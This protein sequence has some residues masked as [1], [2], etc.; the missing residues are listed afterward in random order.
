MSPKLLLSLYTPDNRFLEKEPV[1]EVL[2]PSIKGELGL[3]PGHTDLISLLGSGILKYRSK[4]Q[5]NK[6]AVSWGYLEISQSEVKV[7][8]ES[9]KTKKFLKDAKIEE[10]LRELEEAMKDP[11]ISPLKREALFKERETLL[12]EKEL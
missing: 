3:L 10:R 9:A 2:V 11:Y 4:G 5:W 1:E 12:A 8:A 7:L 6:V